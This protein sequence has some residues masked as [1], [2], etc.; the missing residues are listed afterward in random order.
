MN[1]A[2]PMPRIDLDRRVES[3]RKPDND[4]SHEPSMDEILASIRRIISEDQ[5]QIAPKNEIAPAPKPE[6]KPVASSRGVTSS[7]LGSA[8]ERLRR[9]LEPVI[10][11]T[12]EAAI[13]GAPAPVVLPD[14]AARPIE[15][16]AK[17]EGAPKAAPLPEKLAELEIVVSDP[18]PSAPAIAVEAVKDEPNLSAAPEVHIELAESTQAPQVSTAAYERPASTPFPALEKAFPGAAPVLERVATAQPV[19]ASPPAPQTRI[20]SLNGPLSGSESLL[21]PN[22]DASIASSFQT[23]ATTMLFQDKGMV[24]EMVK[25]MLRPML[26]NWLDDNLPVMVER[27]VRAEIERVAR[28]GRG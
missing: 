10:E 17:R 8:V 11:K 6:A 25:E 19:E 4:R 13:V 22:A 14:E 16:A 12:A 9:A 20:D 3:D 28:G 24:E 7:E 15:R 27:L 21:S 1:A 2:A 18:V 5:A 26:K 23:L